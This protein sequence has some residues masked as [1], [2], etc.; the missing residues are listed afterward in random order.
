MKKICIAMIAATGLAYGSNAAE[1]LI[2]NGSFED[3][4]RDWNFLSMHGIVRNL[5]RST[6]VQDGDEGLTMRFEKPAD[7]LLNG[8]YGAWGRIHK[9]VQVTPGK[10]YLVRAYVH[11]DK[12]FS[13]VL[14]MLVKAGEGTGTIQVFADAARQ[15]KWQVMQG[16][17]IPTSQQCRVFLNAMGDRGEVTF[18]NVSLYEV[19]ADTGI[20]RNADFMR[21]LNHWT[22]SSPSGKVEGNAENK[23]FLMKAVEAGSR[24]PAWGRLHQTG[25]VLVPGRKYVLEFTVETS[26]GLTGEF[27]VWLKDS[28][29]NLVAKSC[30]PTGGKPQSFSC[31]FT[32]KEPKATLY[33]NMISNQERRA[34]QISRSK[35][36]TDCTPGNCR[37]ILPPGSYPSS[38][39]HKEKIHLESHNHAQKSS[40][41]KCFWK[42]RRTT[43]RVM[44]S[45]DG[46]ILP[47]GKRK[48]DRKSCQHW[49]VPQQVN[50]EAEL[51]AEWVEDSVRKSRISHQYGGIY[52]C[53]IDRGIS[54]K[55]WRRA[56]NVQPFYV[57]MVTALT[58]RNRSW[59]TVPRR[60]WSR[61]SGSSIMTTG[62]GW[63][64]LDSLHL[65]LIGLD[66]AAAMIPPN[67]IFSPIT[68][69]GDRCMFL[70]YLHATMLGMT[71]LSINV[72]HGKAAISFVSELPGVD[73]NRIGVMGLSGGGTM[74]VWMTLCDERIKASEIICYSALWEEFGINDLNYCGM[75]VAPGLFKLVYLP[76]L[77]VLI[78]RLRCWWTSELMTPVFR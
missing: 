66:S 60:N 52:L 4:T 53:G 38:K 31:P 27:A 17:F 74:A 67:L 45:T 75:Q 62:T 32:A 6:V 50:P 78:A 9:T 36:S 54:G 71:S 11:A 5:E 10:N 55:R 63:Q 41:R 44:P 46:N 37:L 7:K 48:P 22:F 30:P 18:D 43:I 51:I 13:G 19:A 57:V 70:Y 56:Q 34:S 65:L 16:E 21:G 59:A 39:I 26:P 49:K 2:R 25:I 24:T 14:S 28:S 40:L 77:Q 1:N 72:A 42:W 23:T 73:K 8:K 64:K 15:G 3:E 76:E 61:P 58:V 12:G 20:V 47:S 68:E 35:N 69:G 33:L 29:G